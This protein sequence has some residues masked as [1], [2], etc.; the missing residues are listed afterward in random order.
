[1][2]LRTKCVQRIQVPMRCLAQ[3]NHS[4]AVVRPAQQIHVAEGKSIWIICVKEI[5]QILYS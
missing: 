4:Y 1:M 3:R 2:L 5:G